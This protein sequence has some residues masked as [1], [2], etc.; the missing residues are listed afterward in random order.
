[1]AAVAL[2]PLPPNDPV[3]QTTV[4]NRDPSQRRVQTCW[5]NTKYLLSFVCNPPPY[6]PLTRRGVHNYYGL[7]ALFLAIGFGIGSLVTSIL[8]VKGVNVPDDQS[9]VFPIILCS[10]VESACVGSVIAGIHI[11]RRTCTAPRVGEQQ[12][13]LPARP[14]SNA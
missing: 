14:P 13:L 1:M 6:P 10:F 7:S 8:V 2:R 5:E 4:Q 3:Q 11:L 12:R 9:P